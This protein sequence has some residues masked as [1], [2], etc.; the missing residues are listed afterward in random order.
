MFPPKNLPKNPHHLHLTRGTNEGGCRHVRHRFGQ[1]GLPGAW[2]AI[3]QYPTGW[4]DA[5]LRIQ[6]LVRQWQLYCLLDRRQCGFKT[7]SEVKDENLQK[8]CQKKKQKINAKR[9]PDHLYPKGW[10][11]KR[12]TKKRSQSPQAY[13][14]LLLLDVHSTNVCIGHIWLLR[15]GHALHLRSWQKNM[16][17]T[18]DP[19]KSW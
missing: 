1:H 17:V 5:N 19:P 4:I 14:N 8:G 10:L 2:R 7:F 15:H 9:G 12:S 6:F 3:E 16:K 18:Q 11:L 13:L